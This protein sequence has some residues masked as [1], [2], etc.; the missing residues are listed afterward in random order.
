MAGEFDAHSLTMLFLALR[1]MASKHRVVLEVAHFMAH[2][3][4]EMGLSLDVIAETTLLLDFQ[5]AY[6]GRQKP[7]NDMPPNFPEVLR[8]SRRRFK[9]DTLKAMTGMKS[10]AVNATLETLLAAFALNAGGRMHLVRKLTVQELNL[11][12]ALV[13]IAH[14]RSAFTQQDL[15]ADFAD[16]LRTADLLGKKENLPDHMSVW[17]ALL[18]IEAMH[19]AVVKIDAQSLELALGIE[20]SLDVDAITQLSSQPGVQF[21]FPVFRTDLAVKNCCEGP[22]LEADGKRVRVLSPIYVTAQGK[23]AAMGDQGRWAP[24]DP[25]GL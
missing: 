24:M 8:A 17:L 2:P 3:E 25:I 12:N 7:L 18:A 13:S 21:A 19:L 22:L 15:F 14:V 16:A 10:G 4:R 20:G 1:Q 6:L 11:V 5:M 23:L 9:A